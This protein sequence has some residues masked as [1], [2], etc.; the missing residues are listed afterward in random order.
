M[1]RFQEAIKFPVFFFGPVRFTSLKGKLVINAPLKR[2]MIR[3]GF[4]QEI[5]QARIG[6]AELLLDGTFVLN[7]RFVTSN[8][9]KI[10]ILKDATLEIGEGSHFG[11]RTVVAAVKRI[12]L[13]KHFRLSYES[14]I[15]DSNFHFLMDLETN[16]VSNAKKEIIMGDYCWVGNRSSIMKGTVTPRNLIIASNSLLN[17]D[18]TSTVPENA[19][20]GGTPARLLR[21]NVV[22]VYDPGLEQ[23]IFNYFVEFPEE[24]YYQKREPGNPPLTP[25]D[26]C[27]GPLPSKTIAKQ[28]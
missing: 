5:G 14:Q 19:I 21:K 20:I 24:N 16:L 28:K 25:I 2:N 3:F 8:D 9:C 13:G 1:L 26:P 23:S 27:L 7:G 10:F 18:Y 15:V 6:N 17:K 12:G 11:S 22:R 4:N